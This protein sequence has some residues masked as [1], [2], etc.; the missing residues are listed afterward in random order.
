MT[1]GFPVT[2]L[3]RP[4]ALGPGP[5]LPGVEPE[6]PLT[7][8]CASGGSRRPG[9]TGRPSP[10]PAA[11]P[12]GAH[13]V[14]W[15]PPTKARGCSAGPCSWAVQT[16]RGQEAQ[17]RPPA[18]SPQPRLSTRSDLLS[19]HSARKKSDTPHLS[20]CRARFSRATCRSQKC[21]LCATESAHH[22]GGL[23]APCRWLSNHRMAPRL[24][25]SF[26]EIRKT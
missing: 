11:S 26:S 23:Q 24:S 20:S 25:P 1:E 6:L 4:R 12:T 14:T 13:S 9:R 3:R 7:L 19:D 8:R 22:R 17:L 18:A 2:S 5:A 15:A 10:G 16:P 21:P